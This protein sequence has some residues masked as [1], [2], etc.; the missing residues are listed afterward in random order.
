MSDW[1]AFLRT[2]LGPSGVMG[3]EGDSP[4]VARFGDLAREYAAL[5][6]SAALV[7]R[8]YRGLL[9]VRGRDSIGW[10]H[11]LTTNQ[12]KTLGLREGNYAFAL[13]VQGR[14]LFDLSI[15][16]REDAA[17]VDVDRRFLGTALRH[18]NKYVITEDVT[19]ADAGDR[20]VRI[21]LTGPRCEPILSVLGA[22]HGAKLPCYAACDVTWSGRSLTFVRTDFCGEFG[23]EILCPRIGAEDL[24]CALTD[25]A[26]PFRAVPAGDDVVQIRRVEAGVPWPGAEIC[27]EYLPAETRQLPRAVNFNKGCYLGQEVVER[28]R[29]RNVVARLLV[30]LRIEGAEPPPRGANVVDAEG[31]PTG[32]VTSSCHS[33]ACGGPIALA[34]VKA[35]HAVAATGVMVRWGER[36]ARGLVSDLPFAGGIEA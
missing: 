26:G 35:A 33:P 32:T 3:V 25:P 7:D 22:S 5:R 6:A 27:E 14:I 4:T 8:S 21:G 13:S 2:Q 12:I 23:V 11:N 19:I 9:E 29:S 34:C 30:G 36:S 20:L 31:K 10:L 28:M 16:V 18:F 15:L 17:W 1:A 24:W